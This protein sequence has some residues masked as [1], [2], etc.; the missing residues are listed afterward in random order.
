[1]KLDTDLVVIG[2]GVIGLAVSYKFASKGHSVFLLEK[3]KQFGT[4]VSSRSSEVIHAGVYYET[5]SLKG[6]LCLKGKDL[7]YYHCEKYNVDHKKIGKLFIA[8]EENEIASL[9]KLKSQ[10]EENGLMDLKYL[11]K[12]EIK[13]IEPSLNSCCALYSPS[14]GIVDSHGLMKSLFKLNENH[15]VTY[16]SL[17]PVLNAEPMSNGWK[18]MVGGVDPISITTRMVINSAGLSAINISNK[19]FPER[20]TP[21]LS[22]VKG[23]YLR[24]SGSSPFNHIIYPAMIPG[25][26]EERVDATPDLMNS[27]KFGPSVEKTNGLNDFSISEE[28]IDRFYPSIKRYFPKV[29]KSKLHL[30]QAGIRPKIEI[31]G[32]KN[33]DFTFSWAPNKG[34]LDLWGME[35]PALTASL[36]ISDYTYNLFLN[37]GLI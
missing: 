23:G 9:E 8:V 28:L 10:A 27:L 4:G 22:P 12:S 2:A 7:L 35:S 37:K 24:L 20:K 18:V 26:I 13:K 15:D 34:W 1:L 6:S 11:N 3:E 32:K 30:D 25:Q 29:N 36:A 31:D 19:I 33:S 21:K 14:T 17:S 5:G 16:A